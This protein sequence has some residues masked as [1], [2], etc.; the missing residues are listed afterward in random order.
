MQRKRYSFPKEQNVVK[1]LTSL[2]GS[3]ENIEVS[4]SPTVI[5]N[6]GTKI[7]QEQDTEKTFKNLPLALQNY[8]KQFR[9]S[10]T[11]GQKEDIKNTIINYAMQNNISVEMILKLFL[12]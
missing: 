9:E 3:A 2:L 12:K 8:I 4:G 7:N 6:F 5:K 11:A 10:E 1:S